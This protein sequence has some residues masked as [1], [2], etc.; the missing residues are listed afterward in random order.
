MN[1]QIKEKGTVTIVDALI[2]LQTN[3]TGHVYLNDI[4]SEI[5]DSIKFPIELTDRRFE[6]IEL[7]TGS[8]GLGLFYEVF[9]YYDKAPFMAKTYWTIEESEGAAEVTDEKYFI[10]DE[11][12]FDQ[13]CDEI[14]SVCSGSCQG[15]V[16]E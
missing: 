2:A 12:V 9:W 4:A 1:N 10:L 3:P 7:C 15:D 11:S 14:R 16:G 8:D 13:V 5:K 6:I